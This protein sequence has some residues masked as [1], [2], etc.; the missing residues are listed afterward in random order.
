MAAT[1]AFTIAGGLILITLARIA[2]NKWAKTY[3]PDKKDATK[4][5]IFGI[6]IPF[7]GQ[8]K[9]FAV[10]IRNFVMVGLPNAFG[11]LKLIVGKL[12]NGLF[13]RNGIFKSATETMN[14]LR[15]IGLAW[16][17]GVTKK[18]TGTGI[19]LLVKGIA[20]AL[21]FFLPGAGVVLNAI[22]DFVPMVFHY[23]ATQIALFWSNRKAEKEARFEAL[24]K[25]TTASGMNDLLVAKSNAIKNFVP[26]DSIPSLQTPKSGG[27]NIKRSA[28]MRNVGASTTTS[29]EYAEEAQKRQY[30]KETSD[31]AKTAPKRYESNAFAKS[32][33]ST[34]KGK[35]SDSKDGR[36]IYQQVYDKTILPQ[37]Q[38]ID[39]YVDSLRRENRFNG[40]RGPLYDVQ[41]GWNRG[42]RVLQSDLNTPIPLTPFEGVH[43]KSDISFGKPSSG[44]ESYIGV[45]PFTWLQNGV[46]I[47]ANPVQF[48]IERALRIRNI[49]GRMLNQFTSSMASYTNQYGGGYPYMVPNDVYK[50]PD[51]YIKTNLFPSYEKEWRR[52]NYVVEGGYADGVYYKDKF[53]KFL[54]KFRNGEIENEQNNIVTAYKD[55]KVKKID[56]SEARKNR[57][58]AIEDSYDVRKVKDKEGSS[59]IKGFFNSMIGRNEATNRKK[60]IAESIRQFGEIKFNG[61]RYADVRDLMFN[62]GL[63]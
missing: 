46:Q 53:S 49:W 37:I 45:M 11:K 24:S 57:R 18:V 60:K 58:L 47:S 12:K 14:T 22:A 20:F 8:I 52:A 55:S 4:Y 42:Y 17:L 39:A 35:P 36:Q 34:L 41:K 31:A 30:E 51:K 59:G 9:D 62:N 29:T 2:V 40:V 38:K 54:E 19:K 15:K 16:I 43:D 44:D 5:T 28:I 27:S 50:D 10:G 56:R 32:L 48:E 21:N 7:V 23:A 25:K 1:A 33:S 6:E 63:D 61:I 3:M 13:G 26:L